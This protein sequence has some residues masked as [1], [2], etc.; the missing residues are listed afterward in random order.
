METCDAGGHRVLQIQPALKVH[1]GQEL[2]LD[3]VIIK[4]NKNLLQKRRLLKKLL[5]QGEVHPKRVCA[6]IK[7]RPR[8]IAVQKALPLIKVRRQRKV[9]PEVKENQLHRKEKNQPVA[10]NGTVTGSALFRADLYR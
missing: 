8:V 6:I 7:P 5:L 10:S 3:E 1:S 4:A 2:Q 9:Q